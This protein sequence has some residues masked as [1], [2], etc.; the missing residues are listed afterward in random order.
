MRCPHS[1]FERGDYSLQIN[2]VR[3]EDGG[4]YTCRVD[5]GR[6]VTDTFVRL[7]IIKGKIQT[8]QCHCM[9]ELK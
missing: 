3:D 5:C 2:S 1:Q 9:K 8:P 7:R 6:Q 4:L